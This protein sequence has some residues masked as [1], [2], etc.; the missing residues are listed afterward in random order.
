[1]SYDPD[2][3]EHAVLAVLGGASIEGAAGSAGTTAPRL[4]DAIERYRAAGRAELDAEPSGWHQVDIRFADHEH[5][6][7]AFR[8]HLAP[9]LRAEPIGLWWFVRKAPHWRLRYHSATG[10]PAEDA[11]GHVT[12]ALDSSVSWGVAS[13]WRPALYE[14]ETVAFGGPTG[15]TLAHALF[16]ADSDGMLDYFRAATDEP[17]ELL[18]AKATSL[19]AMTLLMRAARLE[20]G[21]Q[22][23]VWGRV[24]ERRPLAEEVLPEQVS[25]M[26]EPMRRLLLTDARPLLDSGPLAPVRAWIEALERSGRHL[27]EAA[28]SGDLC[29]GKRGVLARHVLFHWNRMGFTARQQSIWARAA[30]VAVLGAD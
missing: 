3:V 8:A 14:P 5:A 4:A 12:E 7:Q 19:L 13:G 15:M 6:E 18:D 30:R 2:R 28:E 10:V 9:A 17:S 23:D 27:A 1:M 16:H 29:L 22:G 24:E 11:I 20:F 21:E 26:A 25:A